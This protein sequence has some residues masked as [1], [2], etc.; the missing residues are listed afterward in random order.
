M[1]DSDAGT[2]RTLTFVAIVIQ[3]ILFFI[4]GL[5]VVFSTAFPPHQSNFITPYGGQTSSPSGELLTR[6]DF[7]TRSGHILI[8][9]ASPGDPGLFTHL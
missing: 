5:L 2:A 8:N 4:I 7:H 9:G 3:L 6:K 1:L